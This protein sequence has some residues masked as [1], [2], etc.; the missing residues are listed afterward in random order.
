MSWR[1]MHLYRHRCLWTPFSEKSETPSRYLAGQLPY[2][3][4]L[5][6]QD[7]RHPA[8]AN[9]SP[10]TGVVGRR[11]SAECL[12]A[13]EPAD[14]QQICSD[15]RLLTHFRHPETAKRKI[16]EEMACSRIHQSQISALPK[17][18]YVINLLN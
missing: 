1:H 7:I 9:R 17:F 6:R 14:A 2:N 11:R 3:C 8:G 5:P 13:Q 4:P 15:Q 16:L 10:L 18:H 12:L